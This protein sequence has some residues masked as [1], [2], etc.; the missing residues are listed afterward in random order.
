V[1]R[2]FFFFLVVAACRRPLVEVD[3]TVPAFGSY[4]RVRVL[5]E[6]RPVAESAAAEALR[7]MHRLDSLWSSFSDGSEVVRLNRQRRLRVSA[8]TRELVAAGISAGE[9][10]GGA[11]DITIQPLAAA[12]GFHDGRHRV[13][14]SSELA[15]LTRGVGFRRVGL[16]GDTVELGD[17]AMLDLGGIAAGA[18]VDRGVEVLK[19]AGAKQGLI[20]AGGDI[21]VFGDRTWRIGVQDPRGEG[22]VRVLRLR[23][24]AVSTSG[25]Y[26]KFFMREGV[27]YCHVL[28]PR[29]GCPVQGVASVTVIAATSVAADA[30]STAVMAMGPDSGLTLLSA[31]TSLAAIV[32]YE[33]NGRLVWRE[34]GRIP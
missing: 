5:G 3:R 29:T 17:S 4:L 27:R 24:K 10:T 34:A 6:T 9:K 33:L 8:E 16:K 1:H 20:D 13:P 30:F 18:A 26:Q 2:L 32:A 15:R 11:F 19:A 22:V 23:E 7:E 31:D 21:R 14:D 28:N 12:W 25:D